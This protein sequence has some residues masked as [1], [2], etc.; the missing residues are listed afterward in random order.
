MTVLAPTPA[1]VPFYEALGFTRGRFPPDR[2][3]YTP[4]R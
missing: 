1:T 3:F 2:G 4:L